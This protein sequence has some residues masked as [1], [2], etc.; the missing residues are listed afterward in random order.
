MTDKYGFFKELKCASCGKGLTPDTAKR[1]D[2]G[3]FCH[4]CWNGGGT[5]RQQRARDDEMIA[6]LKRGQYRKYWDRQKR[7]GGL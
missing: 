5:D 7:R 4:E 6:A 1:G 2:I 3:W